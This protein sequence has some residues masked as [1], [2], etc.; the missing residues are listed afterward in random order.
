M[1]LAKKKEAEISEE[2]S[3]P[4]EEEKVTKSDREQELEI[5]L[6]EKRGEL[7]AIK[8][9]VNPNGQMTM[10]QTKQLVFA[11]INN[12]TDED[13]NKKYKT[14]KHAASMTVMD[15]DNRQTKAEA[16]RD[17]AE[18][19]AVGEVGAEIGSDFYKFKDRILENASDL[20]DEARQDPSKLKRWM[21][22]QYMSMANDVPV[23]KKDDSRRKIAKDFEAPIVE[24]RESRS[25]ENQNDEIKDEIPVESDI[26][27]KKLASF[28]GLHSEK[29]R[30]EY[31]D[32]NVIYVDTDL[33]DGWR[34]TKDGFRKVE[35]KVA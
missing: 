3:L 28:M 20:S 14:S 34:H 5:E 6:A 11:D 7:K 29:E 16:K 19:L 27:N 18:A 21:K 25:E 35:R 2:D 8:N 22:S 10:E 4:G 13:F 24:V 12:L 23:M 1:I 9:N 30:K 17:R 26:S 33:G 15:A 31:A 32:K